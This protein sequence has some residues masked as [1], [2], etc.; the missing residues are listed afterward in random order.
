MRNVAEGVEDEVVEIF[1][2]RH[3]GFGEAAEISEIGGAAEAEAQDIHFAVEE[4]HGN[5]GDAE[6]LEGAF[7]FVEDHAGNGAEGGPVVKN[8]GEGAA[9]RAEGFLGSVDGHSGALADGEGAEVVE[10]LDVIGVA[11]GE[12]NGSEAIEA[13]GEGLGA[14]IG[15]GVNDDVLGVAGEEDGGTQALVMGIGGLADG[16]VA[17]DGGDSHGGAGTENGEMDGGCR[18]G[19]ARQ[20][21]FRVKS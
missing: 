19:G 9:D 10:A 3:G 13:R 12:K 15:G 16:T 6:K 2:E 20:E 8:I 14:E 11:V 18:H 17:A 1:E 7:D 21:E 5:D 4:R